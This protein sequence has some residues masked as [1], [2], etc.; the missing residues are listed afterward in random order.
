M[1]KPEFSWIYHCLTQEFTWRIAVWPRQI[2]VNLFKRSGLQHELI[3]TR[4]T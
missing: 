4:R 1:K 2:D 3:Q